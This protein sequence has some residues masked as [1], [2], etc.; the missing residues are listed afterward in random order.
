VT[1]VISS[2]S[3]QE[4][5][6]RKEPACALSPLAKGVVIYTLGLAF[7]KL[8][9][10]V[11]QVLL[12]RF[13]GV[14]SYG[15]YSLGFSA[16]ILFQSLA[17][18]GLDSGVLRYCAMY[19]TRGDARKIK[20]TF[21]AAVTL[22]LG[23]S[24]VIAT[25]VY[26]NSHRLAENIFLEPQFARVLQL[27]VL[28][29]PFYV[30]TRLTGTF[31]QSHNDI[32]RM[33]TIQ[34]VAQP[35]L[36][37]VLV[38]GVLFAGWRLDGVVGAFLAASILAAVL[39][40]YFVQHIFPDFSSGMRPVCEFRS[41]AR[42]SLT[43][44]V[45]AIAYQIIL[46]MPNLLLG[47]FST[48]REVGIY[49][50]AATLASP[51]GF[52]SLIFAT[53]FLP[54]LVDLHERRQIDELARLYS[55]VTRWTY[56][57]LVPVFGVLVLFRKEIMGF[58][59]REFTEGGS[60]LMCLA[61]AW[62]LYYAKGPAQGLLQMTGRQ[63]IDVANLICILTVN[64][65]LDLRLIPHYGAVGAGIAMAVSIALWAAIEFV[66][67]WAIFGLMPLGKNFFALVVSAGISF[68]LGF[69]LKQY[70]ASAAAVAVTLGIY[71]ALFFGF[72]IGE[73]DREFLRL[74]RRRIGEYLGARG[75]ISEK[76]HRLSP[77]VDQPR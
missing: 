68:W 6:N 31:S 54:M 49:N 70:F 50:A 33:T 63:N 58:F 9:M 15:L 10:L 24:I 21:L 30:L 14:S 17:L 65:G 60:I 23:A 43:L 72:C 29:L 59:G 26:L 42:Y 7:S 61:S 38:S 51:P 19:R 55:T 40:V 37:L 18:L 46:R 76:G 53:P 67:A 75:T 35:A 77:R 69:T 48:P 1:S 56:M 52:L 4:V 62:L 25:A 22:A 45:V 13:L 41:L 28:A 32:L 3:V 71:A 74:V 66:E 44:A 5:S 64:T 16:L 8:M 39:G 73:E 34:Q 47:Y 2:S 27:F 57:L 36:N 20:G 11:T 12:G